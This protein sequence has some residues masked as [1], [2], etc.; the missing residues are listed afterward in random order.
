MDKIYVSSSYGCLFYPIEDNLLFNQA[1]IGCGYFNDL[2]NYMIDI[3][4]IY[5]FDF[6]KNFRFFPNVS[7]SFLI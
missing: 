6:K 3:D 7:L 1:L 2:K 5:T 4:M